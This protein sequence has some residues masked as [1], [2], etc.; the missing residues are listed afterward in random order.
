MLDIFERDQRE[1]IE[2]AQRHLA[3]DLPSRW[4]LFWA[5]DGPRVLLL[6][7]IIAA[8]GAI[9]YWRHPLANGLLD[10]AAT[11]LRA[12]RKSMA[13]LRNLGRE[14]KRRAE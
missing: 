5:G 14:I 12:A 3:H 9:I 7:A 13:S 11:A 1:A 10:L 4:E 2:Y 6:F 8:F